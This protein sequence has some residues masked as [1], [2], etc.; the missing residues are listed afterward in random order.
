MGMSQR[1]QVPADF[2]AFARFA[3]REEWS[4]GLPLIPPTEERV[5]AFLALA[6]ADPEEVVAELP[7][8]G[9]ALTMEKLAANAVMTRARPESLPLLCAAL[10]AMKATEFDLHG[11]NG[12]PGSELGPSRSQT[13]AVS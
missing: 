5:G 10:R 2:E 11:L 12:T 13:R 8:S 6:G 9:A 1:L 4:D 3:E 7:P